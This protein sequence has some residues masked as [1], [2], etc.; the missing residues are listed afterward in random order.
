MGTEV[1]DS[2]LSFESFSAFLDMGGHAP[3]VWS[4]WGCALLMFI[5]NIISP[6]RRRRK[7]IQEL[8]SLAQSNT[9]KEI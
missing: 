1:G 9:E 8:K 2:T 6:V 3:Y 4:A 5:Y 7:I